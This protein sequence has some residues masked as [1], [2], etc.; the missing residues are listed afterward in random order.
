MTDLI[1]CN[2]SIK[3]TAFRKNTFIG[4]H[5]ACFKGLIRNI[6]NIVMGIK[7]NTAKIEH[8]CKLSC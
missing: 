5:Q 1:Y 4:F 7:N 6:G 2:F 3:C 8:Q